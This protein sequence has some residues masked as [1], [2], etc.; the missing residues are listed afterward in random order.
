MNPSIKAIIEK[1]IY[2]ATELNF[3]D[4]SC[5]YEKTEVLSEKN[6]PVELTVKNTK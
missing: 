4:A 5:H 3:R 6:E 2:E 1:K